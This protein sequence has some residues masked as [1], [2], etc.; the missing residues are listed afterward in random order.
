MIV[1]ILTTNMKGKYDSQKENF[2]SR[3]GTNFLCFS[4]PIM[5]RLSSLCSC[6]LL[7]VLIHSSQSNNPFSQFGVYCKPETGRLRVNKTG[8]ESRYVRTKACVGT[9]AS[10][11]HPLDHSPYF[12]KFCKCC[13]PSA[14]RWKV[15]NLQN[16]T[17]GISPLVRVESAVNC[18]CSAC[19]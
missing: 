8:C 14:K 18:N 15:F 16:C 7:F 6:V 10:Y 4:V 3:S 11:T 2:L 5:S 13:K 9:C 1:Q 17:S 12:K 19:S